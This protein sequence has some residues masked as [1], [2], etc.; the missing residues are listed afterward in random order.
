M[1]ETDPLGKGREGRKAGKCGQGSPT[2]PRSGETPKKN[3]LGKDELV[4]GW[5][6]TSRGQKMAGEPRGRRRG[7]EGGKG[8][9][10][11]AGMR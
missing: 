6:L 4:V 8:S 3:W 1:S 11:K 2:R 5:V 10:W 9:V 7:R